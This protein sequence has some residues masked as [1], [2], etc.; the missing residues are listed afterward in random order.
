MSISDFSRAFDPDEG[1]P[2]HTGRRRLAAAAH[3]CNLM[4]TAATLRQATNNQRARVKYIHSSRERRPGLPG[5]GGHLAL[6]L[7]TATT[8]LSLT[9]AH[10]RVPPLSSPP[11][12]N[13]KNN[14]RLALRRRRS[15]KLLAAS[16][17][18]ACGRRGEGGERRQ[19][20]SV[21]CGPLPATACRG[22]QLF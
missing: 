3:G 11:T 14:L 5:D 7:R 6:R 16:P 9:P 20:Q 13:K 10:P 12:P 18:D 19:T 21:G 8:C 15:G 2:A 1:R 22:R 17:A 4:R